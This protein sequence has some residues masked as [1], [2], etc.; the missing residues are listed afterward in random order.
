MDWCLPVKA[1]NYSSQGFYVCPDGQYLTLKNGRTADDY[2]TV[3]TVDGK[4]ENEDKYICSE[5]MLYVRLLAYI[6]LLYNYWT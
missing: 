5:G 6:K 3:C 1:N 4:W 2:S